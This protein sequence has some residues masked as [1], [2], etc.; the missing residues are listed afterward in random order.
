MISELSA[1]CEIMCLGDLGYVC[2][3]VLEVGLR[4]G[5]V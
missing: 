2:G 1:K 4:L 3:S 5:L